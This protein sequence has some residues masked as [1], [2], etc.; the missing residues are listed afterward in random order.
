VAAVFL[1][2]PGGFGEDWETG[3]GGD[4]E[5]EGENSGKEVD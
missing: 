1:K 2:S 5:K 3:R 4:E